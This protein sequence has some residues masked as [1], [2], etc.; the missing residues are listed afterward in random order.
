MSTAGGVETEIKIRLG[1]IEHMP[2]RLETAGFS[3]SVPRAFEANT[4]FDTDD[5]ALRKAQMLIRL[6]Q[7]GDRNIIT[8]KGKGEAGPHKQR[9]ELETSIG[10]LETMTQIL[11]NLG[12]KPRFR[13]EKFRT[14]FQETGHPE[15]VVTFDETPIGNFLELEGPGDW[16]DRTAKRLGFSSGNYLL[17][18]YAKVYGDDC[19]RRGVQPSNMVFAS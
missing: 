11:A 3:I 15:G 13:Y 12:Y 1:L 17:D 8:W 16:I 4:L 18:S 6:R 19:A 5:L 7:I 14:E 2:A 10:S 9:P